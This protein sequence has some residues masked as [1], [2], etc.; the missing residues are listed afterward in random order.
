M[1]KFVKYAAAFTLCCCMLAV[2]GMLSGI[3]FLLWR[4]ILK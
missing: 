2:T 1:D 4:E 3:V